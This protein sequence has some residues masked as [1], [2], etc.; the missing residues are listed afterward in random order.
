M[1]VPSKCRNCGFE[2]ETNLPFAARRVTLSGNTTNC[3]RCG[4]QADIA[5]G[6][7]EFVGRVVAAARS[8]G[9]RRDDVLAFR[10]LALAAQA[11]AISAEDAATHAEEIGASFAAVWAWMNANGVSL[12]LL[13][14]VLGLLV[15][16]YSAYSAD[17]AS[18][19]QHI[20]AQNQIQATA[21][22]SREIQIETQVQQKI[23]EELQKQSLHDPTAESKRPPTQAMPSSSPTQTQGEEMSG[24]NRHERRKAEKI[25]KSRGRRP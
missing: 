9:V 1:R 21:S 11:G 25:S 13:I 12:G 16:A 20:D 15:A 18:A 2:F 5:S 24:M 4:S 14:A 23:Y 8:P 3:P 10:D 7:Y 19:Q 6:T 22:I 17:E